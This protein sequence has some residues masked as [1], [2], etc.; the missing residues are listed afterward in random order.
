MTLVTMLRRY[1]RKLKKYCK[2]QMHS[3]DMSNGAVWITD[4]YRACS[5][6]IK[7]AVGFLSLEGE[8]NLKPLFFMCKDFFEK[9][10]TV[11]SEKII[12]KFS[13]ERLG[14]L[15]C[16][17]LR[18]LLFAAASGV[19]CDNLYEED[20]EEI[21]VSC[22]KNLIRLR[23]IDFEAL[24]YDICAVERYLCEDPQDIYDKM[25]V[26]TKMRYRKAVR[27]TAEKEKISETD[28]VK[29]ILSEA[30]RDNK[31]IGFYI[32][33]NKDLSRKGFMF[34]A[35]EWIVSIIISCLLGFFAVKQVYSPLFFILPVY[36]AVKAVSD[37]IAAIV[38]KPYFL[39]SLSEAAVD[40]SEALIVVS[41]LLPSASRA[42]ELFNRLS[43]IYSSDSLKGTKVVLLADPGNSRR[44]EEASDKA[45]I[46]AVKRLIDELNKKHGGGFLTAVRDR[47][48]FSRRK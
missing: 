37:K 25:S 42:G 33:V 34:I 19:I 38:F 5:S 35:A 43:D 2:E 10:D 20:K 48:F 9:N 26:D 16:E 24:F 4:N 39:P 44:P 46:Q 45:D 40:S 14:V 21:I 31:H 13:G 18:V 11:S 6:A 12:A 27:K 15:Q 41:T 1:D 28:Y 22:V 17:A 47:V 29:R 8:K 23:E 30:K 36:A 3:S 7:A 32:T